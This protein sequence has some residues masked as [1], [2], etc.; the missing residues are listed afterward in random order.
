IRILGNTIRGATNFAILGG[1]EQN[2]VTLTV[3]GNW[4]DGGHCTLKLQVKKSWTQKATVTNNQFGPNRVVSSCPFTAFP[5]VSLTQSGNTMENT[6]AK[7][8]PLLLVS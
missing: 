7:V 6:G 5:T 1:A 3:D 2:N 8:N 4:L